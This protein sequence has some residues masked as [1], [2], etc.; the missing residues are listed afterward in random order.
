MNKAKLYFD[1]PECGGETEAAV[2]LMKNGEPF[3][4]QIVV[5]CENGCVVDSL[6]MNMALS[7]AILKWKKEMEATAHG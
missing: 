7:I 2:P 4:D 6:L 1:C 5:R 3:R